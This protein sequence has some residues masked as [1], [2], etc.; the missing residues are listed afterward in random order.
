MDALSVLPD[1]RANVTPGGIS[2]S[3]PPGTR[4]MSLVGQLSQWAGEPTGSAALRRYAEV[5]D[6]GASALLFSFGP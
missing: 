5:R 6:G 4:S 2:R 3:K 1:P